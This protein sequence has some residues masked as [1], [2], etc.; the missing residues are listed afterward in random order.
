MKQYELMEIVVIAI[1]A[2]IG[3]ADTWI[4]VERFG[5]IKIDWFKKVLKLENG[6]PSHD[7]FGRVFSMIDPEE[8]KKCF[9]N[10]IEAI[11]DRVKGIVSIDGK[12][13]RRSHSNRDGKAAIHIISAWAC[14]NKLVLGQKKVDDK[15]N[16]ITAIPEL[17]NLLM[18][19]GCI[20][21]IDAMGCQKEIAEKIVDKKADY[22]LAVKGNQVTLHEDLKLFFEDALKEKFKDVVHDH[23]KTLNKDHGCIEKR[24]Y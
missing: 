22:V 4:D 15:S 1:C 9:I 13:I 14:K 11:S 17:L 7:T 3:G 10:W 18:L 21:T 16:E 24:E 2:V 5:K 6:I 8:F 20:V 12:T 23:Y 19:E